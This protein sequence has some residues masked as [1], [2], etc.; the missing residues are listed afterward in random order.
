MI[1]LIYA[2]FI[3][4]ILAL[5]GLLVVLTVIFE[6]KEKTG[7]A[8]M[9]FIFTTF[10]V[11][12]FGTIEFELKKFLMALLAY[13]IIGIVWS[14]WRY[15]RYVEVKSEAAYAKHKSAEM[16][17]FDQRYLNLALESLQPKNMTG[18]IVQW[19]IIWPFSMIENI[20]GDLIVLIE[21][22]VT[23]SL[24]SIYQKIYTHSVVVKKEVK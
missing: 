17:Q 9:T 4:N 6:H 21:K 3:G 18:K 2:F 8:I 16:S 20:L 11:F 24:N 7:M 10:C 5:V 15:K 1:E 14:F 22:I 23:G 13:G 12:Y 19:I